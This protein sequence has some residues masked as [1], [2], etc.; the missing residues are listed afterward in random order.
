MQSSTL[1]AFS[2]YMKGGEGFNISG[3]IGR[4]SEETKEYRE[5]VSPEMDKFIQ[6]LV[7]DC[8]RNEKGLIL[9]M[10]ENRIKEEK[11]LRKLYDENNS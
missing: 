7:L 3:L 10:L 8:Y 1:L 11:E 4:D 5:L 9:A 6:K 2:E